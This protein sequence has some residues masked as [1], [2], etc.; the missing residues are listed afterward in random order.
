MQAGTFAGYLS[1]GS[2]AEKLGTKR[3]C[4]GYPLI[5]A[6]AVP[7]FA[8][9]ANPWL[10]LIIGPVVGFFGTGYFSGFAVIAADPFPTPIRAT[11]MDFVYNIGRIASADAPYP[12]GLVSEHHCLASALLITNAAFLLAAL[13][14][15]ALRP[16]VS[17][18]AA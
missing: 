8:R 9:V 13:I 15:T 16:D 14:A 11:P 4:I 7:I 6:A 5:A 17:I 12:I 1:F 2:I 18:P 3:T 10:L